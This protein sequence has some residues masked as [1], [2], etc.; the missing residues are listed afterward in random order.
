[1]KVNPLCFQPYRSIQCY[2]FSKHLQLCK[3]YP[4]FMRVALAEPQPER[5]F[6][7]HGWVTFDRSVNIKEICW[8]ISS[9]R[10]RRQLSS[11]FLF[12]STGL[13]F[14]SS[15]LTKPG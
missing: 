9:I 15:E 5:N 2:L 3:R 4:G 7:R 11:W 10:V 8:N 1:M 14:V 12:F 13:S 6:Q